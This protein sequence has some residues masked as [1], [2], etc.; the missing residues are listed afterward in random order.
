MLAISASSMITSPIAAWRGIGDT[1]GMASKDI[2][3]DQKAIIMGIREELAKRRLSRAALAD[4]AKISL[5]SLEKSLAGQRPFT[6][7][8]LIRIERALGLSFRQ[9]EADVQIAPDEAG[10]YARASVTWL[11]GTYLTIRPASTQPGAIYIYE[12]LISWDAGEGRLVFREVGRKDDAYAQ[13]GSVAFPQQSGHIYLVTNRHGQH[14]MAILAR[15][16]RSGELFGL[17]LTL[18]QTRG[19]QLHPIAMPMVLVPMKNLAEKPPLGVLNASSAVYAA[20]K[21][22]LDATLAE[23]YA[24]MLG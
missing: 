1:H 8:A 9:G 16:A 4:A 5:S 11:E 19:A 22:R 20:L 17:L 10:N 3:P 15:Q 7:Q 6:D 2:L 14:R 12:T 23:G 24:Q 13:F 18:Q 21:A